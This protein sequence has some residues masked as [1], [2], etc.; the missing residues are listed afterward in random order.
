MD[1][2]VFCPKT[3]ENNLIQVKHNAAN[4]RGGNDK[5][6]IITKMLVKLEKKTS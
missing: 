2:Y 6:H 5:Q 1:K 3:L 4:L